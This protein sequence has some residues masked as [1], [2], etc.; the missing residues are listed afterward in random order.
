MNKEQIEFIIIM[1]IFVFVGFLCWLDTKIKH[2][3]NMTW[4]CLFFGHK[5]Y[6]SNDIGFGCDYYCKNCGLVK[7]KGKIGVK[8]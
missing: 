4:K 3:K 7:T 6:H 5:W 2:D 8:K 1:S